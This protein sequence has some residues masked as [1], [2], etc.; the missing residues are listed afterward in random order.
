M[1]EQLLQAG[2]LLYLLAAVYG[3]IMGS[4]LNV[5][6]YRLPLMLQKSWRNQCIDYLQ[7]EQS[8]N[9]QPDSSFN[10]LKPSSHCPKCQAPVKPY[11]NIPL[12]SYL[13]L[14][15]R[16]A[17][18]RQ[19]I[20]LRY[21]FIEI[22][23]SLLSVY[24]V[25]HFG[26]TWQ[27]PLALVFSWL[28]L[29]LIF[30][31]FDHLLLPDGLTLSLLWLGLLASIPGYFC[32]TPEAIIGAAAGYVSLWTVAQLFKLLTGREGMG[33]GDFKLLAA[34]GAWTGWQMLIVIILFSSF[35]GA[36]V[37]IIL[38]LFKG[39]KRENPIP[40]GPYLAVAGWIALLWGKQLISA[41]TQVLY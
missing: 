7:L 26:L 14:L 25:W 40:F 8:V 22:C 34:L 16:C 41:Y 39:H 6:I 35:V 5:V 13:F 9:H 18:C 15:G 3:L 30:I 28:L 20:S 4:F 32:S 21:P 10:L 37:G 24:L 12:L 36:V 29:C 27:M 19:A 2:P 31:D 38:T 23:S 33:H 11:A 1:L 17:N